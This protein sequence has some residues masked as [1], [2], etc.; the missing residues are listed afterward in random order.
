[1]KKTLEFGE[2][3]RLRNEVKSW[4]NNKSVL[5]LS[6]RAEMHNKKM[7]AY[8]SGLITKEECIILENMIDSL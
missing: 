2:F 3:L 6:D 7:Q 1:M 5:F 8:N 4:E